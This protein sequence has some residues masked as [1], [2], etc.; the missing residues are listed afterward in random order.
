[1]GYLLRS[2]PFL[3][4]NLNRTAVTERR[5]FI[6]FFAF[7]SFF[8]FLCCFCSI[9]I[10]NFNRLGIT[11]WKKTKTKSIISKCLAVV[12]MFGFIKFLS[13]WSDNYLVIQTIFLESKE[14][15]IFWLFNIYFKT[16]TIFPL[17]LMCLNLRLLNLRVQEKSCK[18][19]RSVSIGMGSKGNT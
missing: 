12:A 10:A 13:V 5:A 3:Q 16:I 11:L 6:S 15:L 2:T 19:N 9:T 1:M 8:F 14:R 4:K 7:F 18:T 17:F